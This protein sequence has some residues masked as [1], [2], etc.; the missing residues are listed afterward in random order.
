MMM[1]GSMACY[2]QEN[3]TEAFYNSEDYLKIKSYYKTL[4]KSGN[5]NK[6]EVLRK[7]LLDNLGLENWNKLVAS[8]LTIEDWINENLTLTNFNSEQEANDLLS[9]LKEI[10]ET[11]NISIKEMSPIFSKITNEVGYAAFF[12]RINQNVLS[13]LQNEI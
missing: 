2:S 6:I 11:N 12:K 4:V 7:Q 10:E 5:F 1:A 9:K 13:E 3:T 8:K